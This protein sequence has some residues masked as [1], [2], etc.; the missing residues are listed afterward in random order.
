MRDGCGDPSAE[1]AACTPLAFMTN[2]MDW[3]K[4]VS[5]DWMP[6]N[7]SKLPGWNDLSKLPGLSLDMFSGEASAEAADLPAGGGAGETGSHARAAHTEKATRKPP[8]K[9]EEQLKTPK[10]T[11]KIAQPFPGATLKRATPEK[12]TVSPA[13]LCLGLG[14]LKRPDKRPEASIVWLSGGTRW[15]KNSQM[16]I[17]IQADAE[18][19]LSRGIAAA[20]KN[21]LH[22]SLSKCSS[23]TQASSASTADASP[24]S[25]TSSDQGSKS[26]A[27][28]KVSSTKSTSSLF[29]FSSTTKRTS[30]AKG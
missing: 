6:A 11:G 3:D 13:A 10:Q 20:E 30:E 21:L 16:S 12:D 26:N 9:T 7:M 24:V 27:V 17:E 2:L 18:A 4:G 23:S 29:S 8:P 14:P 28:A 25:R 15:A 19:S 1:S 22:R 5:T